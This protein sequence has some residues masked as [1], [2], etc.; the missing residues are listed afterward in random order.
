MND[1]LWVDWARLW[2]EIHGD[3]DFYSSYHMEISAALRERRLLLRRLEL[4]R[5]ETAALRARLAGTRR[6]VL[7]EAARAVCERC[8]EC[9]DPWCVYAEGWYHLTP[10]GAESC[11]A[12]EIH[13]LLIADEDGQ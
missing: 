5:L 1:W 12:P 10:R 4:A 7:V 8:A 13:E 6:E 2:H 9:A 3:A 11:D